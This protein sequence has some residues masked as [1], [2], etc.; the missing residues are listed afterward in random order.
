MYP[1]R[2]RRDASEVVWNVALGSTA[3][4]G[5]AAG[6]S[7]ALDSP[8]SSWTPALDELVLNVDRKSKMRNPTKA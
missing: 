7:G 2:M 8:L 6:S 4:G 1:S 3:L 5:T